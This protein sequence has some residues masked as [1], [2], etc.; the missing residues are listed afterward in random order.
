MFAFKSI[1]FKYLSDLKKDCN[2]NYRLAT[3]SAIWQSILTLCHS[4]SSISVYLLFFHDINH[5]NQSIHK[6]YGIYMKNQFRNQKFWSNILVS[7][8]TLRYYC[9]P[10]GVWFRSVTQSVHKLSPNVQW[11]IKFFNQKLNFDSISNVLRNRIID[12]KNWNFVNSSVKLIL[13][14]FLFAKML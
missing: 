14:H 13:K 11:F 9:W 2:S 4:Y 8:K 7:D 12:H 5:E 6:F 10:N 3:L 1:L